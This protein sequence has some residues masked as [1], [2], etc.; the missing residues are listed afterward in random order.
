MKYLQSEQYHHRQHWRRSDVFIV[1]F[2][3]ISQLFLVFILFIMKNY[4]FT[5]SQLLTITWYLQNPLIILN[6]IEKFW[7]LV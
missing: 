7:N 6:G 4:L 3:H 2:E 5:E 1:N